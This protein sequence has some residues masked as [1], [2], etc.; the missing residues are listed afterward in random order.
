MLRLPAGSPAGDYIQLV[1]IGPH[2]FRE[3]G[4]EID[5]AFLTDAQ[6]NVRHLALEQYAFDRVPAFRSPR[7]HAILAGFALVL[8]AGTL[9]GWLL[10]GAARLLGGAA[11]SPLSLPSRLVASGVCLLNAI[12][13]VGVGYTLQKVNI[14][15]LLI[16]VPVGLKLL[17]AL[18]LLSVPLTL[19]LP[20]FAWRGLTTEQPALLTRLHYWLLT[21]T[22]LL[23]LVIAHYWNL[24]GFRY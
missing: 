7:V 1:E 12:A 8:F 3:V 13:L 21:G 16:A 2:L 18:L 15:D 19:A 23:M 9:V 11:A 4:G 22:A 10:G 20:Y 24:L 5:A 6:G 14:Y 17:L